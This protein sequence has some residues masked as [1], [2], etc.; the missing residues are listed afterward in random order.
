MAREEVLKFGDSHQIMEKIYEE[1]FI[2]ITQYI[3]VILVR[4]VIQAL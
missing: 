1:Y 4:G 2:I 3:G